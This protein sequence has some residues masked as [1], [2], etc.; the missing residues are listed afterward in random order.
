MLITTVIGTAER[1]GRD[2]VHVD[3]GAFNGLMEALETGNTLPYP[4]TDSRHAADGRAH[5]TGPSCDSQDTIMYD[6][7]LST[8]LACG[9]HVYVGSAGAYTTAYASSFNG[10]DVPT[11][12]C[13]SGAK[14]RARGLDG[15][16]AR[17]E[18]HHA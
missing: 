6:A 7:P 17:H 9:D 5:L 16:G 3:V 8:G 1:G 12:R 4:L 14:A 2:W 10:F 15:I 11:V 13:V 18:Q